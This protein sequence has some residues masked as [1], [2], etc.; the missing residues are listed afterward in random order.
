MQVLIDA[1]L[2]KQENV[3]PSRTEAEHP[4]P[5]FG[6]LGFTHVPKM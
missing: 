3:G 5:Q 2:P 1:A 4:Q 6:Q